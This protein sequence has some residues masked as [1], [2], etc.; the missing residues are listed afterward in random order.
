MK[1]LHQDDLDKY[2]YYFEITRKLACRSWQRRN[3]DLALIFDGILTTGYSNAFA[4]AL[5]HLGNVAI[6][7]HEKGT[8]FLLLDA[9][10]M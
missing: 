7:S 4:E 8:G 6:P 2:D 9:L 5:G 1:T 10:S 3:P